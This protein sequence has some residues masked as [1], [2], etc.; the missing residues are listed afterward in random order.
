MKLRISVGEVDLRVDGLEL[1]KRQVKDLLT[2][3]ASIAVALVGSPEPEPERPPLGFSAHIE[4]AE[5]I[6]EDL[7]EYF[8]DHL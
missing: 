3:A 2:S 6:E 7:S 4:R 8:E 1:T 5:P